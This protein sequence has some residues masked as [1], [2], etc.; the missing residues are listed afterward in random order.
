MKWRLTVLSLFVL[1]IS[2]LSLGAVKEFGND[3]PYPAQ[4]AFSLTGSSEVDKNQ[5]FDKIQ[6][7][8]DKKQLT[9]YRPFLDKSGQQ[10]TFVFGKIQR[11]NQ[12]Y[13]T[14][15]GV[16]AAS[17]ATGMYYSSK[18]LPTELKTELQRF[19][20]TYTGADLPWYLVPINFL[21]MNLRSLAVWTLFFVFAVL[22]FAVKMLYVKKAMIQ[23]SLGLFDREF[24]RS[25]WLD[26]TILISTGI[27]VWLL[28]VLW[29][30]SMVN[31][32]VKTFSLLLFLNLFILM[33]ISLLVNLLFAL[34]VRLMGAITVLKNKK[35][36]P[37][38]LYIWLFGILLSCF[39]FGVTASESVKTISKSAQEIAVLGNWKI[40]QDYAA[41]TWFENTATHTDENH[42]IDSTFIKE[43]AAKHRQLIQSFGTDGWLYSEQSSLSPDRTKHAPEEFKQEL[44]RN[45]VDSKIAETLFYVNTGLM[46]K[47]KKLYPQNKYGQA[48]KESLGVIYI[49]KSQM[50]HIDNI[51][52]IIN[53]EHFRYSALKVEDFQIVEIPDGQKTFLFNHKDGPD[54]LLA[55]Q[56]V[57]NKILVQIN[58]HNLP[59]DAAFD[60]YYTV[61]ATKGAF[62]QKWIKEKISQAGLTHFSSMTNISEQLLL[63]RENIVSQLTGTITALLM[64]VLA[65]FFIIYEYITTRMK[66][67]AKKISLQSLLGASS[68]LEIFQSLLPLIA[69][70]LFVSA[71][72]ILVMKGSFLVVGLVGVLYAF[73]ITAMSYFALMNVRKN[74][75]QIIKGDFEIL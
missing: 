73:E 16:L 2:F 43:N 35:S 38:V 26:S 22:L 54:E 40:A 5:I 69:G 39:I 42:Q 68:Y 70:I 44:V 4:A 8:A 60:N 66:Q 12:S 27:L 14:D 48:P 57:V 58:F 49:P 25:L 53:Y 62:K 19:G 51:R 3:I 9:I 18:A 72:T 55:K 20:L 31:V 74:R 17:T 21:F 7:I 6:E 13:I 71:L 61:L 56:E 33:V 37:L 11:K 32:Y 59:A 10:A 24:R 75:V 34:N 45:G 1:L 23:R 28:F 29:Q 46:N 30:G 65:Q 41:I 50:A 47:N 64:L 36:N 52:K 63:A 15:R 67:K